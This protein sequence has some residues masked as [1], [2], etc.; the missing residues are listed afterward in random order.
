MRFALPLLL[1]SLCALGLVASLLTAWPGDLSID[2]VTS[3]REG[4]YFGFY[5][6]QEPVCGLLW[7]GVNSLVA[8][9]VGA[10][11]L[12]V[13]QSVAYWSAFALLAVAMLRSGSALAALLA[14]AAAYLPPL[15]CFS[16]L[17]D[18]N[19]V[20][21]IAWLLAVAVAVAAR[22][23]TAMLLCLLL[24]WF[25]FAIRSG[26]IAA[27]VPVA[28][29]C[30]TLALPQA[31]FWRRVV[32]AVALGLGMQGVSF[33]VT[34]IFLGGPSRAQV[35]SISQ[36]FDMAGVYKRTGVHH[37]P[38]FMVPQGHAAEEVLAN[39]DP[40][41][42]SPLFWRGDGKPVFAK[43]RNAEQGA[44]VQAAW[45]KTIFDHPGAWLAVKLDFA[46]RFLMVG[47][48]WP[49]GRSLG[50]EGNPMMEMSQ[51]ADRK[52]VLHNRVSESTAR[53]LVWRGWIW[54]LVAG[55]LN[56]VS[57]LVGGARA[58]PAV[59][60]FA[61]GCASIV[62]HLVL[63]QA[64]HCRYYFLPYSLMAMSVVFA[65]LAMSAS[66]RARFRRGATSAAAPTA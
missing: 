64:A 5:G 3:I 6:H 18:S 20:C 2:M 31:R 40:G 45:L 62:P 13:L 39:Y 61:G 51:P 19:V 58:L 26:M 33:G 8:P 29:A 15:A 48:E 47:D 21:G 66:L 16:P 54:L 59:A 7:A 30:L 4:V 17:I 36:A 46:S 35:L 11:W 42:C 32:L 28:F 57:L 49:P 38:T 52:L 14:T 37:I 27:V 1:A 10:T 22:S 25:G 53:W 34:K 63:G 24:L 12:F 55:G 23:R 44:E 56:L 60:L 50:F 43:A 65:V 9:G 41:N